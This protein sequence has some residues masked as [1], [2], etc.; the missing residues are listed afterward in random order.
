MKLA[1]SMSCNCRGRGW[2]ELRLYQNALSQTELADKLGYE[3]ARGR[4]ASSEPL[5]MGS[6]TGLALGEAHAPIRGPRS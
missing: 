3:H 1:S 6:R 2:P 4:R 5:P